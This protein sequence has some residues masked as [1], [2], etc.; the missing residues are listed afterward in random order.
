MSLVTGHAVAIVKVEELS[1]FVLQ[2]R[3]NDGHTSSVDFGTF[4]RQSQNPQTR[5]F[6]NRALFRSYTIRDGNLV[7]GDYDMCFAIGDLYVGLIGTHTADAKRILAVAEPRATY[8]VKTR[9]SKKKNT[10]VL[11][12]R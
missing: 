7:W 2:L 4:L 8:N 11:R 9:N 3:F 1:P 6:L 10:E 5:Q 12:D